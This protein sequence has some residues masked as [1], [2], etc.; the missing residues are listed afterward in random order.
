MRD[1]LRH[2]DSAVPTP[3]TAAD[4]PRDRGGRPARETSRVAAWVKEHAEHALEL[5]TAI[6]A[7]IEALGEERNV[8]AESVSVIR[9]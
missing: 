7:R 3:A 5:R 9:A 2:S 6:V 4:Q 1:L 8:P